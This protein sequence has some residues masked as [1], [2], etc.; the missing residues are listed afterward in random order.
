MGFV[1]LVINNYVQRQI[2]ATPDCH[3]ALKQVQEVQNKQ[4]FI[5]HESPV[6]YLRVLEVR[7]YECSRLGTLTTQNIRVDRINVDEATLVPCFLVGIDVRRRSVSPQSYHLR[8]IRICDRCLYVCVWADP[9]L[10]GL[11][12]RT[13]TGKSGEPDSTLD[14]PSG[15][16]FNHR[17]AY[18]LVTKPRLL[19]LNKYTK[20]LGSHVRC[21]RSLRDSRWLIE[22]HLRTLVMPSK[23]REMFLHS[24]GKNTVDLK[25]RNYSGTSPESTHATSWLTAGQAGGCGSSI[26]GSAFGVRGFFT[27]CHAVFYPGQPP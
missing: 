18:D 17:G 19:V 15:P 9:Y 22:L 24:L 8:R 10:L 26:P 7:I 12:G 14:G 2:R 27:A 6:L 21:L 11:P 16:V 3:L 13:R 23:S 4:T 1:S 5:R 20:S 25:S